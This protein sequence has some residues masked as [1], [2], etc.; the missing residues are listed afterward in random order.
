MNILSR[1]FRLRNNILSVWKRAVCFTDYRSNLL[2]R[3]YYSLQIAKVG[4][5]HLMIAMKVSLKNHILLAFCLWKSIVCIYT[6][7]LFIYFPHLS[8]MD[9]AFGYMNNFVEI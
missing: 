5:E 3:K 9:M 4:K 8:I 7:Y 1:N 6:F 2:Q